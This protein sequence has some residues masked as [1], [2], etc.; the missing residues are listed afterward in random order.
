MS[1]PRGVFDP[2][3]TCWELIHGAAAGNEQDRTAFAQLYLPVVRSYLQTRWRDSPLLEEVED[4]AQDVFLECFRQEGALTRVKPGGGAGGF[5]AF[6]L[7]TI[8]NIAR[9]VEDRRA[10]RK[11]KD[12]GSGVRAADEQPDDDS[13]LTEAFDRAWLMSLLD[14]TV[15]RQKEM[16]RDKGEAASKRVELLRLRFNHDLPIRE[17]ARRWDVSPERLHREYATARREFMRALRDVLT[18]H[19][20]D[21]PAAMGHVLERLKEHVR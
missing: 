15:L 4:A 11:E 3:S 5:R 20:P 16:A 12:A 14:Q 17:I 10:R 9:R 8:R 13:R 7:A 21:D 18:F 6:L 2:G 19:Y 1:L